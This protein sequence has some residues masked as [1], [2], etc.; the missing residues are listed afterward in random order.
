MNLKGSLP[1]LILHILSRHPSHGYQIAKRIKQESQGVLDFKE[2]SLYP[3]L[4]QM[5]EQGWLVVSEQVENG[6]TRRYYSLT[7]TG[8]GALLREREAWARYSNAINSVLQGV[9][10]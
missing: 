6:R 2:G 9:S 8:Q 3:T 1:V 4:H 5:V 10:A 7:E